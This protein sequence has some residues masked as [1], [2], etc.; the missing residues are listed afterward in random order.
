MSEITLFADAVKRKIKNNDLIFLFTASANVSLSTVSK[1]LSGSKE[2]SDEL[3]QNIIQIAKEMGYFEEKRKRKIEYSK[4]DAITIAVIC[5][6]I[7]SLFYAGEITAIKN[8]IEESGGLCA[9]F[10]ILQSELY[11]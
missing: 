8:K 1:A 11:P 10:W 7:I 3:R 4:S 6:E 2:I 9:V 5:P